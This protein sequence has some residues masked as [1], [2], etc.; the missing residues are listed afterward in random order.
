MVHAL[1]N[2]A[3]DYDNTFVTAAVWADDIKSKAMN[4]W[5]SWHFYGRPVNPDGIYLM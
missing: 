1:D 4:F 3:Y 2:L 5:D